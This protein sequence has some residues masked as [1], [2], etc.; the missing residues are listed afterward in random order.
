M[1]SKKIIEKLSCELSF[2]SSTMNELVKENHFLK[3]EL[4]RIQKELHFVT[5]N[6]KRRH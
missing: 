1:T 5:S 3:T 6:D 4:E 2:A